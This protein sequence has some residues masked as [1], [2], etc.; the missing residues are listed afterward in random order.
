VKKERSRVR[1]SSFADA[2][3]RT[4]LLRAPP[5]KLQ[6]AVA[7]SPMGEVG[8][9]NDFYFRALQRAACLAT[10]WSGRNFWKGVALFVLFFFLSFFFCLVFL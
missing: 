7:D 6:G 4:P 3:G 2:P 10:C 8:E 1:I 9:F 5:R